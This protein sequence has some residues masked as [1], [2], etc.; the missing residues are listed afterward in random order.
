METSNGDLS[1]RRVISAGAFAA[2]AAAVL[3]ACKKSAAAR[4]PSSGSVQ[5]VNTAPAQ[6]IDD[7]VLLRTASSLEYL[8]VDFYQYAIDKG[9]LSASTAITAKTFQSQHREQAKQFEATT[10]Q[11]GGEPFTKRNDMVW[12]AVVAPL[13]TANSSGDVSIKDEQSVL[14]FAYRLEGIA[15]STYQSMVS[16]LTKP[17]L[18]QAVMAIGAVQMRHATIIA[19]L[20]P[21]ATLAP[22]LKSQTPAT[23]TTA[24]PTTSAQPGLIEPPPVYKVPSS[25]APLTAALGP[26]SFEYYTAAAAATTTTVKY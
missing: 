26:N 15:A 20:I 12:K 1:R 21:R 8:A 14:E 23:T 10:T 13:I 5:P 18:R 6:N 11:I 25:F 2:A 24:G 22:L 17:A 3:A 7:I 19:S 4:I 9:K 16:V